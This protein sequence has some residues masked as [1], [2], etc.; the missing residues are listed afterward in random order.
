MQEK[1]MTLPFNFGIGLTLACP[2]LK[3]QD[4]TEIPSARAL[5]NVACGE[6]EINTLSTTTHHWQDVMLFQELACAF[7][8]K[9]RR[10][11]CPVKYFS[12][13]IMNEAKI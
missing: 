1:Y 6:M 9:A 12:Y 8:E 13:V 7:K 3:D 5:G 10:Y 11:F 4:A 2:R